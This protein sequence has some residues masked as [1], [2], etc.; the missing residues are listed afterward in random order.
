MGLR[1]LVPIFLL[2]SG[3]CSAPR[4]VYHFAPAAP[5]LPAPAMHRPKQAVLDSL[6]RAAQRAKL[7]KI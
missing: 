4:E 7:H 1:L 3:S 5:Y 2:V 6:A